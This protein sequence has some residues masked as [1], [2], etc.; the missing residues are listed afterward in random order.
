MSV[1]FEFCLRGFLILSTTWILNSTYKNKPFTQKS[2]GLVPNGYKLYFHK[3]VKIIFKRL[4]IHR[5]KFRQLQLSCI[6]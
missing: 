3:F 4:N 5:N 2:P 1:R 6:N